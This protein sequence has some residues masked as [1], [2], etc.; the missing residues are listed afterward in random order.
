MTNEDIKN[1]ILME[2]NGE[3]DNVALRKLKMCLE[4]NFY[5]VTVTDNSTEIVKVETESNEQMIVKFCFEQKING[6]SDNTIKQYKRE[7]QKFFSVINKHFSEVVPDDISYYLATLMS[8]NISVNSVDNSRKF[9]KPFFKWLYESEYIRKDIFM[10][11]K[12]I[13]RIDKQKDFLTDDEIVNIRDACQEDI[14]ALALVDFLL[15]TGLRVS[16]C[17]N[18][19]LE[20]VDFNTGV[21]NVYATKTSQW[22]KVYLDS[23]ALIHLHDYL[24]T[25]TDSCPYVFANKYRT[26]GQ[27]NKMQNESMQKTV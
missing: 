23:N 5:G 27:I 24:N 20:N 15:S 18:L 2:M 4:R 25:R 6:L 22:R 21:V 26:K 7:T 9:L 19:K 12:P 3:I 8:K 1:R 14:R 11:I 10:K 13:K 17:S 16:E